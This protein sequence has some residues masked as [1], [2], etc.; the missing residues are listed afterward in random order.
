MVNVT[1]ICD[2]CGRRDRF[3]SSV[4]TMPLRRC[5]KV[6]DGFLVWRGYHRRR[7]YGLVMNDIA[8]EQLW[9]GEWL[10]K[11]ILQRAAGKQIR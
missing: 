8:G 1:V 11:Q 7:Q 5:G 4:R 3:D 2:K 6:C 9:R 10:L